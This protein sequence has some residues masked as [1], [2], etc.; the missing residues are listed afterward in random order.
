MD[1]GEA[2]APRVKWCRHAVRIASSKLVVLLLTVTPG[3][4]RAEQVL[5]TENSNPV[6]FSETEEVLDLG[7]VKTSRAA[8][9]VVNEFSFTH[10]TVNGARQSAVDGQAIPRLRFSVLGTT[11][12]TAHYLLTAQD[13]N[14]NGIPDWQ[15]I[16]FYGGLLGAADPDTY[17]PDADSFSHAEELLRGY[18]LTVADELVDGGVMMRVSGTMTY[19]D[20]ALKKRYEIRSDPQGLV[21]LSV[22]YGDAGSVKTT[23]TIGSGSYS[24]YYFGYWEVDGVRQAAGSGLALPRASTVLDTDKVAVARFFMP[25]DSDGDGL[26]DWREWNQFGS[27]DYTPESDPDSDGFTISEEVTR[28]YAQVIPDEIVDGGL[29]M[30]L[31]GMMTYRDESLKKRYEIRSDPQG[32]VSLSTGYQDTGTVKTTPTISSGSHSGYYFGYWEVNGVRQAAGSGV[33]LPR[34]SMQL[35]GDKVAVARFFAAGDDDGDGLDDWREWNQFGSLTY[36]QQGDPDG[37]NFTIAVEVTR[38]YSQ[39]VPD[40]IVDGGVM[41]RLSGTTTYRDESLKK[42]YEIRSDP[43]GLVGRSA[44]YEDTGTVKATPTVASGSHS[45]YY[46]GYWEVNGLRQAAGSGLALPRAS[47]QLDG[48]KVAV[49]RFFAPGDDDGDG[50]DD[51]HEWN[52]F[53]SLDYTSESDPDG[54][55]FAIAEEVVRGYSSVIEDEIRDGGTMMRSSKVH[56]LGDYFVPEPLVLVEGVLENLFAGIPYQINDPLRLAGMWEDSWLLDEVELY[57]ALGDWDA[58]GDLDFF[59]YR[60]DRQLEAFENVGSSFLVN[61]LDQGSLF[62]LSG[63]LEALPDR[64]LGISCS[65]WDGDGDADL[66]LASRGD[67][68]GTAEVRVIESPGSFDQPVGPAVTLLTLPDIAPLEYHAVAF[69]D[70]D[71]DGNLDLVAAAG[72]GLLAQTLQLYRGNGSA[73]VFGPHPDSALDL[74]EVVG[75]PGYVSVAVPGAKAAANPVHLADMYGQMYRFEFRSGSGALELARTDWAASYRDF[76]QIPHLATGDWD[77]D[78]DDDYLIG[79]VDVAADHL[80]GDGPSPGQGGDYNGGIARGND[81]RLAAPFSIE[82]FDGATGILVEWRPNREYQ[83]DG[84]YLFRGPSAEGPWSR[85]AL[86]PGGIDSPEPDNVV[87]FIDTEGLSPATDYWYRLTA[88]TKVYAPGSPKPTY[89]ESPASITPRAAWFG[90]VRFSL[91]EPEQNSDGEI[92][93]PI[94]VEHAAEVAGVGLRLE[95]DYDPLLLEPLAVTKTAAAND[96]VLSDNL[97]TATG[98]LVLA[99]QDGKLRGGGRVI[100]VTFARISTPAVPEAPLPGPQESDPPAE[101]DPPSGPDSDP[102]IG[103]PGGVLTLSVVSVRDTGGHLLYAPPTE[104][105][106]V[107]LVQMGL[108]G[109]VNYDGV[110][111]RRDVAAMVSRIIQGRRD[112]QSVTTVMQVADLNGNGKLDAGDV[113]VLYQRIHAEEGSGTGTN[114]DPVKNGCTAVAATTSGRPGSNVVVPLNLSD[115]S[116]ISAMHL[117]VNYDPNVLTLSQAIR[118]TAGPG[119]SFALEAGGEPGVLQ[120]VMQRETS[121]VTGSGRM[122]DLDFQLNPGAPAGTSAEIVVAEAGLASDSG[123]LDWWQSKVAQGKSRVWVTL[124]PTQDTDGDGISDFEE[125][126][127]ND[128]LDYNPY[129]PVR[130]PGGS[131]LRHDLADSDG[132]GLLDGFETMYGLNPTDI[133]DGDA[134]SDGD[135]LTNGEEQAWGTNPSSPDSDLDG[136]PDGFE[137]LEGM[138]PNFDD[139]NDDLERDGFPNL[140]EYVMGTDPHAFDPVAMRPELVVTRHSNGIRSEYSFRRRVHDPFAACRLQVSGDLGFWHSIPISRSLAGPPAP[141]AEGFERVA[142]LVGDGDIPARFVRLVAARRVDHDLDGMDDSREQ[143]IIDLF[144]G[145]GALQADDILPGADHD[146]DGV[147]NAVEIFHGMNS[148]EPGPRDH[149]PRLERLLSG[150]RQTHAV[151]FVRRRNDPCSTFI[152]E[153]SSDLVNWNPVD[154]ISRTGRPPE[155]MGDGLERLWLQANPPGDEASR[156]FFRVI[157][158]PTE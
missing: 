106:E 37:D 152:L 138:N 69:G 154:V 38:G 72:D 33:A 2:S 97:A 8:P 85:L 118:P 99:G 127:W 3:F 92:V 89:H 46:F 60:S 91:D 11:E 40:E 105:V 18:P 78:G 67:T 93:V 88:V 36:D 13:S 44:G 63:V 81:P 47:I 24:G 141:E 7:T 52:Q 58:D 129:D 144:A 34:V 16:R 48:D 98:T 102:P 111:D 145:N 66:L 120:I 137:L 142:V 82:A 45:G 9:L 155:A 96:L 123:A 15:E 22:G 49:A 84:Y 55:G 100:E 83:L 121:L 153:Q 156:R 147:A 113:A 64:L 51:W 12:A 30:R 41:M 35:D 143:A 53:D 10:W 150:G 1:R 79:F 103:P 158:V 25:G 20:E 149:L 80:L 107:W 86:G 42:R 112:P 95:L 94:L 125:Q 104:E 130:N 5:Y 17:D 43:Q 29:M 119:N 87:R 71:G 23:P 21:S 19:R 62:N 73:G 157:P 74:G 101:D 4:V 32:L 28:G 148:L 116:G 136:M 124:S 57:P 135:G 108:A 14:T 65:D 134:D 50:L 59:V 132:D 31:S 27:L 109:D 114:M 6:V 128:S 75:A 56:R 26:D 126:N 117:Q 140:L 54:D 139:A 70:V 90:S 61:I 68:A 110:I 39:V 115:A 77:G 76:A 122:V 146:R 131:D 133:S 151:T